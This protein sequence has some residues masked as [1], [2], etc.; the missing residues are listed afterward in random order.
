M[1]RAGLELWRVGL[2]ADARP[3]FLE[4]LNKNRECVIKLTRPGKI[5]ATTAERIQALGVN[6]E[7]ATALAGFFHNRALHD[8]ITWSCDLA[9]GQG[10]TLESWIFPL[11]ERSN[12]QSVT[13]RPFIGPDGRRRALLQFRSA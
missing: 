5:H 7:T 4:Y 9:N 8:P 10:P 3:D 13:V 6:S 12:I 1:A 11:E 2:I